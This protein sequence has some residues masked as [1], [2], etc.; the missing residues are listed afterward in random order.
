M[1]DF[2]GFEKRLDIKFKDQ[3]LLLQAFIHRSYINENKKIKL[4][5]NERLE[6]LGDAVLELI[7]TEYLYKKY[8][9]KTE[10]DLTSYRSALVN[11]AT[12]SKIGADLGMNEFLLLSKGEGKDTGRARGIILANTFESFV[13]A[14]YLDQG[15]D[16]SKKF[17]TNHLLDKLE[18]EIV[19][20]SLWR[21]A[22]SLLQ[23]K[24][25]EI[26]NVTPYY[27][28]LSG[29]GPDHNKVFTIGLYFDNDLITEG[30]GHSKQEAE[31]E[32]AKKALG[33]YKWF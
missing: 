11:A 29:L 1:K 14:L 31:Q 21:D 15:Y 23:E 2:S 30:R 18:E 3:N 17:I 25:Q 6:F 22:K 20:K 32:A 9:L 33:I 26:R 7:V 5:H 13:G 27:K 12:L 4:S 16:Q 19:T 24:A 10:G 8:P 28:M